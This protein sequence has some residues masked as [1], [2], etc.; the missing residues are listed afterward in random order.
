M[1]EIWDELDAFERV[2][3]YLADEGFFADGEARGLVAEVFFA[4]GLSR[5]LRRTS[6]PVPTEPCRLPLAA[7]RIGR[8]GEAPRA[9]GRFA[10]GPWER[11]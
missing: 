9:P 3:S 5:S 4:Y 8:A 7:C 6:W 2:E 1:L 11:S 10:I